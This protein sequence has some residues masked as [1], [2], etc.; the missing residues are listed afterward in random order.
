M[1]TPEW[2]TIKALFSGFH[3]PTIRNLVLLVEA[4]IEKRTTNLNKLKDTLPDLL[5]GHPSA[6]ASN[7]GIP[8]LK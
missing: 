3:A 4:I 8:P 5:G 2:R 6:T 7:Y 1:T